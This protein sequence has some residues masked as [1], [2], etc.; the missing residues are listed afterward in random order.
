LRR[1]PVALLLVVG[2][3]CRSTHS[4]DV[5]VLATSRHLSGDVVLL[6]MSKAFDDIEQIRAA[7]LQDKA[8]ERTNSFSTVGVRAAA[9]AH[10]ASAVLKLEP[11]DDFEARELG[12][13]QD[14][15]AP[16]R[17]TGSEPRVAI[18]SL[19]AQEL[20]VRPG[21]LLNVTTKFAN[22]GATGT[23]VTCRI[24][25]LV[26]LGIDHFDKQLII[27]DISY[28]STFDFGP[29][30]IELRLFDPADRISFAR[31]LQQRLGSRFRAI[32]LEELVAPLLKS[33]EGAR[34]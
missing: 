22:G 3:A 21:A 8:V 26:H 34:Q 25:S 23:A 14:Q 7:L 28:S 18:G 33:T 2:V 11:L 30:G 4:E 13:V 16:S 15:V 9:G 27:A 1:T 31:H 6:S 17:V 32:P 29:T 19:L 20:D 10:E 24:A 5:S 12:L